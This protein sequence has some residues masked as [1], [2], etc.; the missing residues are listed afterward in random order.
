VRPLLHGPYCLV[1]LHYAV[2][3][4]PD[5]FAD[6]VLHVQIGSE[7]RIYRQISPE[8]S[9]IDIRGARVHF[10]EFTNHRSEPG[11]TKWEL[12]YDLEMLQ[13]TSRGSN[14]FEL[15]G[16]VVQELIAKLN[17][18]KRQYRV[19]RGFSSECSGFPG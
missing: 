19:F 8:L 2:E 5:V 3:I 14:S 1:R 10:Q 15:F 6:G 13:E 9:S 11:P 7:V 18:P 12:G 4:I 16:K 17:A